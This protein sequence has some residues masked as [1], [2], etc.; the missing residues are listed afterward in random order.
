MFLSR[1][2]LA[3]AAVEF[4]GLIAGVVVALLMATALYIGSKTG[5]ED[6]PE[7][8]AAALFVTVGMTHV[9]IARL[10]IER[11]LVA[12]LKA[13]AGNPPN[14]N[15]NMEFATAWSRSVGIGLAVAAATA[16]YMLT[17]EMSWEILNTNWGVAISTGIVASTAT[18]WTVVCNPAFM[19]IGGSVR[20]AESDDL[21]REQ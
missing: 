17:R 5:W 6:A 9:I 4:S 1:Q 3:G 12:G 21:G 15:W 16:Y 14:Q 13:N 8:K 7:F 19:A 10:M 18:K 20:V 2:H 11:R